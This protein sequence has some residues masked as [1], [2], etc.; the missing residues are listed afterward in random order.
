MWNEIESPHFTYLNASAY[1]KVGL[2]FNE[3]IHWLASRHHD[4]S[5]EV[6][7]AFDLMERKLLEIPLLDDFDHG[8]V[9]YGL[10]VFEEFLSIW[11]MNFHNHT[12]EIWVMKEYKLHFSWTKTL[13]IPI[14]DDILYFSPIYSTKSG[15]IIGTDGD[16]GLVKYNDKGLPLEYLEMNLNASEVA[17]Y[18]ESLLS[19]P[20]DREQV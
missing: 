6:I 5:V 8:L 14:D 4:S 11:N 13:V 15:D 17:M 7:V 18:K 19:F 2:F 3:A 10:W 9:Y 16:R 20:V 1:P 12:L